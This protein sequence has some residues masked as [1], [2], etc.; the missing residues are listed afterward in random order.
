MVHICEIHLNFRDRSVAAPLKPAGIQSRHGP[1]TAFPRPIGRG[2]IEA[3]VF[4]LLGL[5]GAKF[6]RPIG[7]GPIEAFPK[8]S[9]KSRYSNFRDRSVAAPLK[10]KNRF[11]ARGGGGGEFS[12][13]IGAGPMEGAHTFF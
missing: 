8:S 10:L 13:P 11:R 7:R 12:G 2:P 4:L 5:W 1:S 3:A 9:Y 6:P